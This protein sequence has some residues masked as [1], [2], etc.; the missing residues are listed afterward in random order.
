MRA[1]LLVCALAGGLTAADPRAISLHPFLGRAGAPFAVTVRGANLQETKA[2]FVEPAGAK[3]TVGKVDKASVELTVEAASAGRYSLRLVTAAGVSNAIP[4]QITDSEVLTEPE[5]DH[6]SADGA[7]AVPAV[8][9]PGTTAAKS[10]GSSM[11]DH[12]SR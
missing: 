9:V 1:L 10:R 2:V 5:G 6:E 8:P 7:V 4:I 3:V 11:F 12:T